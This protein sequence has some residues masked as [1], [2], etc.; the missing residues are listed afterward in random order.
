MG[1][2]ICDMFVSVFY[3]S[4]MLFMYHSSEKSHGVKRDGDK[5]NSCF[6]TNCQLS[7]FNTL[8]ILQQH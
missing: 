5:I 8:K 2:Q 6:N 1:L 4:C 3:I 7:W